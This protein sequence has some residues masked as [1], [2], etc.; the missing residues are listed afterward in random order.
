MTARTSVLT[1]RRVFLLALIY[2]LIR[3]APELLAS[4]WG[5]LPEAIRFDV[6]DGKAAW[7]HYVFPPLPLTLSAPVPYSFQS[8]LNA[9]A[10]LFIETA[11]V[12]IMAA[13]GVKRRPWVARHK[14]GHSAWVVMAVATLVW[15]VVLRQMLLGVMVR[16]QI[17]QLDSGMS[18]DA[19]SAFLMQSYWTAAPVFYASAPVWAGVPVWLHFRAMRGQGDAASGLTGLGMAPALKRACVLTSFTLGFMLVHFGLLQGLFM[20][21]WPWFAE[22]NDVYIPSEELRQLGLSLTLGQVLAPTAASV[23][24]GYVFSR[25]A[26]SYLDNWRQLIGLPLLAGVAALVLTNLVL[27]VVVWLAFYASYDLASGLLL[28]VAY[29]PQMGYVYLAVFNILSVLLLC[30]V[31]AF[32]RGA[33]S[34]ALPPSQGESGPVQA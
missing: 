27:L 31:A 23:L 8:G 34:Q 28:A 29:Q 21:L 14:S 33:R 20:G 10:V 2:L 5:L 19:L 7:L 30:A 11:L 32:L 26:D 3:G 13:W 22:V 4:G 25:N 6:H 16:R 18:F 1:R 12:F 24:A 9:W 15:S 17:A